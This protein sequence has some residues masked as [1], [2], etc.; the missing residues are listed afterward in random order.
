MSLCLFVLNF[1]LSSYSHQKGV[2]EIFVII[3]K[4]E[5]KTQSSP[6]TCTEGGQGFEGT[7]N[8]INFC[9]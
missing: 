7:R 3:T 9:K 2:T 1:E 6:R 8:L 5:N 4:K